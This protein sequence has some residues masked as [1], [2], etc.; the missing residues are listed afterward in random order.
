[1]LSVLWYERAHDAFERFDGT[2]VLVFVPSIDPFLLTDLPFA[3]NN[4]SLTGE[5][6]YAVDRGPEIVEYLARSERTPYRLFTTYR[7]RAHSDE[8]HPESTVARLRVERSPEVTLRARI[9]NSTDSPVV[10]AYL[11]TGG[12]PHELVL[13]RSSR[14]GATYDVEWTIAAPNHGG[15]GVTTIAPGA[16][17]VVVGTR[18]DGGAARVQLF[19]DRFATSVHDDEILMVTPPRRYGLA[20]S[21]LFGRLLFESPARDE[22]RVTASP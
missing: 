9:T 10:T 20:T 1:V 15:G 18:F 5:R 13:D 12:R 2:N 21:T 14:R 17:W 19:E 3:A 22:L 11:D 7:D 6:L 16:R 8:P 4:R